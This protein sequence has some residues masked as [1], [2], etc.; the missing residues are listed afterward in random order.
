MNPAFTQKLQTVLIAVWLA[1]FFLG[2]LLNDRVMAQ[3][4]V[5]QGIGLLEA[6]RTTL[7]NQPNI[8]IQK[9]IIDSKIGRLQ[10]ER[11]MFDTTFGAS[12]G[13]GHE[14][15]P[16]SSIDKSLGD[17]EKKDTGV[18]SANLTKQFRTGIK[19]VPGFSLTSTDTSTSSFDTANEARVDF[20]VKLPLLKGRGKKAVAADEMV[21]EKD[22][23]ISLLEFQHNTSQYVQQAVSAYWQYIAAYK[24]LEQLKKSESRAKIFVREIKTL[25]KADERPASDLEQML[26][27]LTDK[28]TSKISGIQTFFEAKQNLGLSMGIAFDK[29]ESLPFP[30]DD[31]PV[32]ENNNVD[33]ISSAAEAIIKQ[34]H[35]LRMDLLASKEKEVS[36]KILLD[37]AKNNLLPQIDLDLNLGYSGLDE[38]NEFSNTFSSLSNNI[39]GL[40]F[41]ASINYKWPFSN[42]SARGFLM[43]KKAAYQR[44]VILTNDL[45]RNISSRVVTAISGLR[46]S[47]LEL[48][49]TKESVLSY[50][51]VVGN[52]NT[53]FKLGMSTLLDLIS[54]ENNL[55]SAL[56]NEISAKQKLG[57]VLASLRFETGTLLTIVR[58]RI[59]VGIEELTT[60][61]LIKLLKPLRPPASAKKEK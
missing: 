34:A 42:N 1:V 25:I 51:K 53:K 61:P 38:G 55:T 23:E 50:R 17:E 52:E 2:F 28:T 22:Y 7:V 58:D 36:A 48:G 9:K 3:E 19:I 31:F 39:P 59:S 5:Q 49:K 18:Y 33:E 30:I 27:N 45:A 40:S 29:I 16:L 47:M 32:I 12:I 8:H 43:Q 37:A 11:G 10:Y 4:P 21:A 57:N 46:N 41:S 35:A 6:V 15:I 44:Q 20:L 14:E 54:S 13:Y 60:V 24:N 26:A 56:L